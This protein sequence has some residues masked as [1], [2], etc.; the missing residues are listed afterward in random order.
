MSQYDSLNIRVTDLA[1]GYLF[2]YDLK[3]WEVKEE[4]E[5]DWGNENYTKEYKVTSGTEEKY[6]SVEVDDEIELAIWDKVS[7][8]AIDRNLPK[9]IVENDEP[10][11][12]VNLGGITYIRTEESNGYWRNT[13][14]SNWD[15]FVNWDYEN[16]DGDKMLSIER[17]GDEEFEAAAGKVVKEF[18]ISNILP[19][20]DQPKRAPRD[21]EEKKKT[22]RTFFF[23]II[24]GIIFIFFG[25]SRCS[26]GG[27]DANRTYTSSTEN[28]KNPVDEFT[29]E[30][31]EYMSFSVVL[32]DMDVKTSGW[33]KEYL[34]Q[35]LII[36]HKDSLSD[37]EKKYTDWYPV[38]SSFYKS[39]ENNLGM[40]LVSKKDGKLNKSISPPGYGSYVGN[41]RY[42]RW[43]TNSR[44]ESFWSF[45]GR[46]MF[47]SSMF[48][49]INRPV[50]RNYY[51]DYNTGYRGNSA[52]YGP[53]VN[54]SS[55]YGT[56]SSYTKKSK[57]YY[58]SRKNQRQRSTRSSRSSSRYS[59][60][61]YRSRGGG[62]GK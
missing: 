35:Y 22:S 37:P 59:G 6:L 16:T 39:N 33:S 49:L 21:Y 15:G 42:G 56:N 54:G 13:K 43:E 36:S 60:S 38:K 23:V 11:R 17:W 41:E 18:E 19:R 48:D 14:S 44:G 53:Q 26:S 27:S 31:L 47:M 61:S 4:Y 25:M 58:Y 32:Y 7:P 51:T 12:E 55:Y 10:P 28:A 46:Y 8:I 9:Y 1:L 20:A 50:Y 3:T 62:F 30:Y 34:H 40:E 24:I 2:D 57:P 29:K 45:Y 5:Y 52:Y